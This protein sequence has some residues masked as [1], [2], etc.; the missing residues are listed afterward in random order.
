M[1]RWMVA[2]NLQHRKNNLAIADRNGKTNIRNKQNNFYLDLFL[3]SSYPLYHFVI[4]EPCRDSGL[5]AEC[6]D[7][8][9]RSTDKILSAPQRMRLTRE[10]PG[11]TPYCGFIAAGG[12]IAEWC[13]SSDGLSHGGIR[14]SLAQPATK[15]ESDL[16]IPLDNDNP[17][18]QCLDPKIRSRRYYSAL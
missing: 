9:H 2:D 8:T 17:Q 6:V 5:L 10:R 1:S 18:E 14:S 4:I 15:S 16:C 11:L 7:L 13:E 3:K 12:T